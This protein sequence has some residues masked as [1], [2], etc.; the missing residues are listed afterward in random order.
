VGRLFR[1]SSEPIDPPLYSCRHLITWSKFCQPSKPPLPMPLSSGQHRQPSCCRQQQ[2]GSR[3]F[4]ISWSRYLEPSR[5]MAALGRQSWRFQP[6][7]KVQ[8]MRRWRPSLREFSSWCTPILVRPTSDKGQTRSAGKSSLPTAQ[9]KAQQI[10]LHQRQIQS[11]PVRRV[12]YG[13]DEKVG[14]VT[15]CVT[16]WMGSQG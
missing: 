16:K 12:P 2:A 14:A 5:T 4:D 10:D 9:N 7:M 8:R 13:E 11:L 15:G 6:R 3:R 1:G